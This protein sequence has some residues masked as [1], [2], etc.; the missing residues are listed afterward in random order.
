MIDTK[1]RRSQLLEEG[2]L[3]ISKFFMKLSEARAKELLKDILKDRDQWAL[4]LT[5]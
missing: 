5:E 1:G 3:N 4:V 2:R